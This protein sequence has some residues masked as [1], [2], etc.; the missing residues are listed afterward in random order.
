MKHITNLKRARARIGWAQHCAI[1][2]IGLLLFSGVVSAGSLIATWAPNSEDDLAGYIVSYGIEAGNHTEEV[3]VKNTTTFVAEGLADG[4]EY[5]FAVKAYDYSGNVSAPSAEVSATVGGP[6]L[7][8]KKEDENIKLIWTPVENIDAYEIFR[9]HEPYFELTSPVATVAA[10]KTEFVDALHFTNDESETYYTVRAI[11]AGQAL[12]DFPTVGAYDVALR[13]GLNLVSLPLVPADPTI[14]A[15]M[16]NQLTGGENSSESDQVR[17]W[18]GEEYQVAWLYEGPAAEYDGQ[19][20]NSATGQESMIEI[21]SK[22]SFW[23]L[24]QDGHPEIELTLTGKVPHQTERIYELQQGYNFVGCGYPVPVELNKTELYEDGVMKGGVGSGEADILS[25]WNGETYE[26]AWVV[27]GVG[28]EM[29]GTWMDETGKN[30]TTILFEPG[31]G[32]IIWIKGD[33]EKKIW[34]F[35]NPMAE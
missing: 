5:Y 3:D 32:Y 25:A 9:S 4:Q 18:D 26:R 27:D 29:D 20:I 34:T 35:P 28:P 8:A 1:L 31:Q 10:T 6:A 12:F 13:A 30:E 14:K 22:S 19:W 16:T 21:D 11:R 17:V 23:V 33:N 24:I 15:T 2:M 7:I